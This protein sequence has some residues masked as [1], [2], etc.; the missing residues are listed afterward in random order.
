MR[1]PIVMERDL[2]VPWRQIFEKFGEIGEDVS[3][4]REQIGVSSR[5]G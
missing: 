4:L 1:E 5:V 2:C 3:S